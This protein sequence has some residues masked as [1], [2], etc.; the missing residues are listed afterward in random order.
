MPLLLLIRH[1]QNDHVKTGRLPGRQP[2]IHLNETGQEEAAALAESLADLTIH[3]LYASPLERA[4]ETAG[5][6]AS[7][8]KLEIQLRP[9]LM[10]TDVGKWQNRTLKSVRRNKLWKLVQEQPSR[11]RF[12]EGESFVEAQTRLV[13]EIEAIC[14]AHG[15]KEVAAVVFHAD[16]IKLVVSYYLGLPLD[17]FQRLGVDTGSLSALYVGDKGTYLLKLNMKPP[18][19]FSVP[20]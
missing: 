18:F 14:A 16:P 19:K 11:M 9:N 4:V 15:P 13:G 1:G 3:G 12:P 10:D 8:H 5:P 2:G 20:K 6:L 7:S 17:R